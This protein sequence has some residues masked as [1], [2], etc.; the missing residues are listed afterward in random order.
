MGNAARALQQ[1]DWLHD[2][3]SVLSPA[4]H[5]WA[6]LSGEQQHREQLNLSSISTQ[7]HTQSPYVLLLSRS[8]TVH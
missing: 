4:M 8:S 3:P 7:S 5:R 2:A 6:S 1:H